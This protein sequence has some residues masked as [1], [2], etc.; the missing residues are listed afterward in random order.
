MQVAGRILPQQWVLGGI[1]RETKEYFIVCVPDRS[2]KTLLP[3]SNEFIF[4]TWKECGPWGA[5]KWGNKRRR[6]TARNFL[7]PYMAEFMWRS[8]LTN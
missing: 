2:E 5:A 8:K 1:C 4:K 3:L 6:G 7:D